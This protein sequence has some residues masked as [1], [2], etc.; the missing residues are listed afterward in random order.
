[1]PTWSHI[2]L[3]GQHWQIEACK[4]QVWT[5][6]SMAVTMHKVQELSI[7]TAVID[8]GEGLLKQILTQSITA[9]T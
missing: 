3:Q 7:V 9:L 8:L 6:V 4:D 5:V 1:M 2:K